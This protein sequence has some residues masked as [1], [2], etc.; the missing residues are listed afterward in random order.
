MTEIDVTSKKTESLGVT[1]DKAGRKLVLARVNRAMIC[2]ATYT[3]VD[4]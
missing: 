3:A 1:E 4:A 2:R